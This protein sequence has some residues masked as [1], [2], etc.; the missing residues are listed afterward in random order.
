MDLLSGYRLRPPTRD[1]LAAVADVLA[2]DD[3]DDAGEVVLDTGFLQ[4]QW[5]R[6]GFALVSDAWIAV[7]PDGTAVAYGQVTRDEPDV[8]GSWGVVHPAHRGRGLGSALLDRIEARAPA[9]LP[10]DVREPK[11]RNAINAGDEAAAGMLRARGLRPVRHFWHMRIDLPAPADHEG[12]A[13]A[14]DARSPVTVTALRSTA[15]LRAVHAVVD[16]AFEDHWG[17]ESQPFDAWVEDFASGSSYDPDLWRLAWRGERLV[18]ALTASILADRGWVNLLGVERESRGRGVAALLLRDAFAGFASRGVASV[19]LA[20]D[21]QNPTGA[22]ALYERV[23]MRTV[24]RW[25]LW[26]RPLTSLGGG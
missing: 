21:A 20:V 19:Y 23:G 22:T 6:P 4:G 1:D 2:A 10:P 17:H 18:G 15:E 16:T 7:G 25:D 9:L 12:P 24:K 8:A 11:L 14:P 5:E 3:L 13:P 26:E